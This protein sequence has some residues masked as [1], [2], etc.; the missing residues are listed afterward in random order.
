MDPIY[1]ITS[2]FLSFLYIWVL[3]NVPILVVGIKRMRSTSPKFKKEEVNQNSLPSVSIIIPVKDEEQVVGRLLRAL[4]KVDYPPNKKEIIIVEDASKDKTLEICEKFAKQRSN[5]IKFF[6]RS[7]SNGKPSALNFGFK[8]A[9]GDIVAVFDAD[10]V[11][12][13]D[14]LMKVAKYFDDPSVAA[15]QGTTPIINADENMLAKFISYEEAVWLKI[16][17]Q[18]KDAL[19]LFVPIAGSCQFI[20]RDVAAKVGNWDENCLAEDLDMAAKITERGYR[21][22]Y[23]PDVISWQEAPSSLTQLIKQRTRW[24]RGHMEVAIKY[25]RFLRKLEKRNIDAEM[26][27]LGP[28]VST[29][30]FVSFLICM[31]VSVLPVQSNIF[32]LTI[33]RLNFL[34]ITVTLLVVGIALMYTTK[35]RKAKNFMWLP[36]IYAYMSLQST[37]TA[38]A[39]LQ[40]VFKRP[41]KWKKTD[42]TGSCTEKTLADL[43][44]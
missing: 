33:S 4:L 22:K 34:L 3:Y 11:P 1:L 16:Y 12:E 39:F 44:I 28:Y 30:F 17:L 2:F 38:Y 26:T 31:H 23:A 21:A 27:L 9:K 36:F 10:N 35:P 20:R 19:D 32:L 41:R 8:Q 5:N 24:L 15:V 13:P 40:I 7:V 18:G 29:L 25:G 6:H 14:V 42:K 43:N 37:L